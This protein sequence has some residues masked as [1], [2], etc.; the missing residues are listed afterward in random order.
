MKSWN[1]GTIILLFLLFGFQAFAQ[2]LTIYTLPPPHPLDWSSPNKLITTLTKN[3]SKKKKYK[4]FSNRPIGHVV[5]ELKN[6][7]EVI[8]TGMALE[9]WHHY[10][11]PFFLWK[12]GMGILFESAPGYL[13]TTEALREEID[14]RADKGELAYIKYL[15][16][17]E[18]YEFLKHYLEF[19]KFKGYDKIYNGLNKPLEGKGAGCSAFAMSFLEIIKALDPSR[20]PDWTIEVLIPNKLIGAPLFEREVPPLRVY[21]TYKWASEDDAEHTH[22]ILFE[23]QFIYDWILEQ[24][25]RKYVEGRTDFYKNSKGLIFDY[26]NMAGPAEEYLFIREG[27]K[28]L[29]LNSPEVNLD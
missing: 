14:F 16:S 22:F 10:M 4:P 6:D 18:A 11:T 5:I 29:Q 24:H 19:Y 1:R 8:M 17:E 12:Q 26:V 2:S 15:V 9:G 3:L 28:A 20:I 21:F 7:D 25:E 13:E 23:P 27:G